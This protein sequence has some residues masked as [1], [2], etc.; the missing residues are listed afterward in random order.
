MWFL[1]E[2]F[3]CCKSSGILNLVCCARIWNLGR[4]TKEWV[5]LLPRRAGH[6]IGGF[7]ETAWRRRR[8]R[9]NLKPGF[10]S[11]QMSLCENTKSPS[12]FS[13]LRPT[14]LWPLCVPRKV[15]KVA[16][17]YHTE[18]GK[19][20]GR[21]RWKPPKDLCLDTTAAAAKSQSPEGAWI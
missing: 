6:V 9:S 4:E 7:E 11:S 13:N 1:E 2:S 18:H 20:P 15:S 16:L 3:R 21:W 14:A 12:A 10:L 5:K 17:Q 19:F 8:E